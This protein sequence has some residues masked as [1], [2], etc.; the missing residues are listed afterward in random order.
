MF[1]KDIETDVLISDFMHDWY[2]HIDTKTTH[3]PQGEFIREFHKFF[4][5]LDAQMYF[6][7]YKQ[8]AGKGDDLNESFRDWDN[9][10]ETDFKN[11]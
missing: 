3:K 1:V 2:Y 4:N 5:V 8:E 11:S 9:E 7:S 10:I 6:N